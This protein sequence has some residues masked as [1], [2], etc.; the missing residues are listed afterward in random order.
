MKP[1]APWVSPLVTHVIQGQI[2]PLG[3]KNDLLLHIPL[4]DGKLR[5]GNNAGVALKD[6]S[7]DILYNFFF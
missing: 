2:N 5:V 3:G 1:D 7:S 4:Q 6:K